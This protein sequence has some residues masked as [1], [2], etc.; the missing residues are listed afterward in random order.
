MWVSRRSDRVVVAGGADAPAAARDRC[1]LVPVAVGV[2]FVVMA[3]RQWRE[4]P[5]EGEAPEEPK[6]LTTVDTFTAARGL[7]LGLVRRRP[8]RRTWRS[9]RRPRP[10]SPRPD[11]SADD[12]A[13]AIAV[14]V[15]L[16]SVTVVGWV[17]F[18]LVAPGRPHV[19]GR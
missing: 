14:F 18:Y 5:R 10:R 16:G 19:A 13:I 11:F 6:R 17:L 1:E 15:V 4:R 9:P 2:L 12:T 7:V 8:I 3:A